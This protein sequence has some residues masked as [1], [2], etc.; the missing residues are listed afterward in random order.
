M[1]ILGGGGVKNWPIN[2]HGDGYLVSGLGSFFCP[3]FGL[4]ILVSL[5]SFLGFLG[6]LALFD[7]S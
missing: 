4:L 5:F 3:L 2:Q 7:A 1:V 6:F